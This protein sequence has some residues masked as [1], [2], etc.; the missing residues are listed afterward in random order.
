MG[1]AGIVLLMLILASI[2][3]L[4]AAGNVD[5]LAH[6]LNDLREEVQ[7][8][9][10]K[11]RS[12][13][14]E[15]AAEIHQNVLDVLFDADT[16]V[17]LLQGGVLAGWDRKFFVGSVD[18][19][20]RLNITG[21]IQTRFVYNHQ[22]RAPNVDSHRA[23]FE[24]RRAKVEFNGHVVDPSWRYRL[25][26]ALN[27]GDGRANVED[28]HLEKLLSDGWAVRIGQFKAPFFREHNISSKRQLAV[29]RSLVSNTF[30]QGRTQGV[31]LSWIGDLIDFFASFND[32]FDGQNTSALTDNVDW[33]FTSRVEF[34]A[35]GSW[36][37]FKDFTSWSDDDRLAVLLGAAAHVQSEDTN[38]PAGSNELMFTWTV[39]GSIEAAG[40]NLSFALVGR[41]LDEAG[42]DQ[43]GTVIQGGM[44]VTPEWELFGRYEWSDADIP[45]IENLSI[46]T[47]G[48]NK[49]FN[50]HRLK[51]TAD[52][53][54]SISTVGDPFAF[55]GG[56]WRE[57]PTGREGQFV[58]R[59][60][61]QL[62]Y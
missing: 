33:A 23:G 5:T 57:D 6:Q 52:L 49:Y 58:A 51:W 61:I 7:Y 17:N 40:M 41:H 29:E 55:G 27:R 35:A 36:D 13:S 4:N 38:L 8:L 18:D 22:K 14:D 50:K 47:V 21:H 3:W 56:G 24:M 45:G 34:L 26:F 30:N 12:I 15:R 11:F 43:I 19:S 44:F 10:E 25:R 62:L 46:I 20:F 53:G 59:T 54:Y 28:A 9:E 37:R 42:L 1:E 31:E 16:R 60:Q 48:I 39:D 32:G 2:I